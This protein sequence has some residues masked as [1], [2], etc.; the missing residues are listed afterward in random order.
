M[1]QRRNR[2]SFA[3]SNPWNRPTPAS[4]LKRP[5]GGAEGRLVASGCGTGLH[6]ASASR[7]ALS[8]AQECGRSWASAQECGLKAG[9]PAP[10][11]A[12]TREYALAPNPFTIFEGTSEIQRL[13]LARAISGVHIK[14]LH[15]D[16]PLWPARSV[17]LSAAIRGSD[18][19][20][21]RPCEM[22]Q[23]GPT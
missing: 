21:R 14:K 6:L 1:G 9:I 4:T 18:S 17:F 8:A 13:I 22:S 16:F 11:T 19:L 23:R 7:V 12:L 10:R 2:P 5:K 3:P 20:G 15:S